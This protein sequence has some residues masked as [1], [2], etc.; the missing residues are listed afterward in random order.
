[1]NLRPPTECQ[2]YKNAL[3]VDILDIKLMVSATQA[4]FAVKKDS[5]DLFQGSIS[6]Q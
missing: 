3:I 1:M 5:E 6:T 4:V 2:I